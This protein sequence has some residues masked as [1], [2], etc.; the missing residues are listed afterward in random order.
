M[1]LELIIYEYIAL[2]YFDTAT[3]RIVQAR[4]WL[5]G[6]AFLTL[7]KRDSASQDPTFIFRN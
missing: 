7:T 6:S 5:V 1:R 4:F 3:A 2:N